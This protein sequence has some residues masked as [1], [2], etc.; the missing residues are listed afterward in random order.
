MAKCYNPD[1]PLYGPN[2]S[3]STADGCGGYTAPT[4]DDQIR[5]MTDGKLAKAIYSFEDLNASDYCQ[6]KKECDDMLDKNI[7]IPASNCICCLLDW[8]R[9]PAEMKGRND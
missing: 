2:R 3:C 4:N 8:L 6:L 5:G 1:C 9:Q 7:D